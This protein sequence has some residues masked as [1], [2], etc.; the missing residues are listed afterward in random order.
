[1]TVFIPPKIPIATKSVVHLLMRRLLG[2]RFGGVCLLV[3]FI[4]WISF[5]TRIV[6]LLSSKAIADW[7]AT[8]LIETFAW[9]LIYDLAAASYLIIPMVVY[10]VILPN[11]IFTGRFNRLLSA[12]FFLLVIYGLLFTS[13]AEWFF[14]KEFG[15]RLNFIAVDYLVYTREV[16][17]NILESYPLPSILGSLFGLTAIF[18]LG[19]YRT[20]WSEVWLESHTSL[21]HRMAWGASILVLPLFFTLGLNNWMAPGFDNNINQELA[22]NG[23]YSLF[24]AFRNNELDY[25]KFYQTENE[26]EVFSEIRPL[27]KDDN[28]TFQ[29]EDL[30]DL[31][32][33]I[34]AKG[35]EKRLNVI[36]ITVESLSAEFMATFGSE[37][38]LTPSLDALA[39]QGIVFTRFYATGTRTDR[40]M[41]SLTLSVPPTPGRSIIKRPN[42]EHL[43]TLGSVFQAHGYDTVFLYGGYGYFDNMNYFF[44]SN[45]YRIVDRAGVPNEA[46]TF[47]NAWGACD[48]NLFDWVLAEADRSYAEA[49]PFFH[50]VMTTSNHRPFTYPEGRIDIPSHTGRTGALKYTDYAIGKFMREARQRPWFRD[51]IFVFV[52]DHCANSAGKNDLAVNEYRIPLILYCPELLQPQR[53]NTLC[54]QIDYPPTLLGFLHWRYESRFYGK[55]VL[56]MHPEDGRAFVANYQKLGY[57]KNGTLIVLKPVRQELTYHC[58]LDSGR[59]ETVGEEREI[60]KQAKAYYQ[61][62]SYGFRHRPGLPVGNHAVAAHP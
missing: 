2:H 53:V 58:N 20:G 49:K 24:S 35:E 18:A 28:A 6:L 45:G 4:L 39:S 36:Q 9:G 51:T 19:L 10:L 43:F 30:M 60:E 22:R 5:G 52:A 15:T 55:D 21:K 1:M 61:T 17:R 8:K 47:A 59:L 38:K 27:L 14:W 48:E 33:F 42:N 41:E 37:R 32:R 3:S 13:V 11:R 7:N 34:A 12:A 16:T 57:V 62:A 44:G 50:F 56:R 46:V 29:S 25:E 54:S 40:G 31:S 23:I 26:Q